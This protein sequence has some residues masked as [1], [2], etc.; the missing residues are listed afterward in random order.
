[1]GNAATD[2]AQLMMMPRAIPGKMPESSYNDTDGSLP[3][4]A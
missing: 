4:P 1:M 2:S 3:I